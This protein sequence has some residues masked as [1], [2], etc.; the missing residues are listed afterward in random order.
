MPFLYHQAVMEMVGQVRLLFRTTWTWRIPV[1]GEVMLSPQ[2][3]P[4]AGAVDTMS[5]RLAADL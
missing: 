1:Q 2:L 4:M 5:S 3:D